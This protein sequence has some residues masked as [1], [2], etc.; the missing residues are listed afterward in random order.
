[1]TP[2]LWTFNCSLEIKM[3]RRNSYTFATILIRIRVAYNQWTPYVPW[4]RCPISSF[5]EESLVY[6]RIARVRARA[7]GCKKKKKKRKEKKKERGE[8]KDDGWNAK[9]TLGTITEGDERITAFLWIIELRSSLLENINGTRLLLSFSLS[10]SLSLP[11]LSLSLPPSP[12]TLLD[13]N[14]HPHIIYF[15][16]SFR[17][18]RARSISLL[19]AGLFVI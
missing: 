4:G 7:T 16:S 12:F 18:N 3:S 14:S 15:A 9:K 19:I 11:V 2:Q 6:P 5:R 1:M 8:K 13:R 10:L 17:E